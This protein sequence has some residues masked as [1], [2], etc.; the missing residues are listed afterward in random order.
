VEWETVIRIASNLPFAVFVAAFML[1]RLEKVLIKLATN[2]AIELVIMRRMETS[3][4]SL[5]KPGATR[6]RSKPR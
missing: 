3:L 1:L 6:R 2:E 4:A 5:A